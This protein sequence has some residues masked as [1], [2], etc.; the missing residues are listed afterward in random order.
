QGVDT[1]TTYAP[2]TPAPGD[3][4]RITVVAG[5]VTPIDVQLIAARVVTVSGRV[6]DS[7]GKP[8]DMGMV[9]L[10]PADAEVMTGGVTGRSLMQDGTFTVTGV[11]PGAYT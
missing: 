6:V 2:G 5:Q 3:A 7:T 1:V 10:R 9:S 11:T 8:L 4:Q